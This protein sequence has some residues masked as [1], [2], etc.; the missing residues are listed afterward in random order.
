MCIETMADLLESLGLLEST[1]KSLGSLLSKAFLDHLFENPVGW[2][3][4]Y[5]KHDP[6]APSITMRSTNYITEDLTPHGCTSSSLP[7]PLTVENLLITRPHFRL[8]GMYIRLP[9]NQPPQTSTATSNPTHSPPPNNRPLLQLARTIHPPYTRFS[10]RLR[11]TNFLS[12][13]IRN[14]LTGNWLDAR[15]HFTRMVFQVRRELGQATTR[16]RP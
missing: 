1:M 13:S 14:P 8:L 12:T 5:T 10:N 15:K 6:T 3:F 7:H 11:T 4:V 16:R 2:Q 9:N